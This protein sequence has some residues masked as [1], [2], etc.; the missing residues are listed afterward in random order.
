MAIA[1]P[2]NATD[3]FQEGGESGSNYLAFALVLA[4]FFLGL[5][6]VVVCHVLKKKGYRF[7]TS[8]EDEEYY[9]DVFEDEDKLSKQ[10]ERRDTMT[11]N[12]DTVGN[13]IQC[14]M[15]NE[16]N[17]DALNA[18]VTHTSV[19]SDIAVSPPLTPASPVSPAAA[20]KLPFDQ[21]PTVAV[22]SKGLPMRRFSQ[23]KSL[24]RRPSQVTVLSVG[25]FRVTKCDRSGRELTPWDSEA[26]FQ[27][28]TD[29]PHPSFALAEPLKEESGE[30]EEEER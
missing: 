6:G 11:E 26:S 13:I 2:T 16:A 27:S 21:Q 4:F 1:A 30:F 10:Q 24:R 29:T 18:M 23:R 15:K 14:I 22:E 9:D 5:S 7:T 19:D 20:A 28:A 3:T 17:S 12:E 8:Q 25:R